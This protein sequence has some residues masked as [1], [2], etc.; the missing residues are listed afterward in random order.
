MKGDFSRVTASN[1]KKKHY[2][3]VLKQ[4]SRVL[5]DADNNEQV[6]IIAHQRRTRTI[7]TIGKCGAPIHNSG[8][9]IVSNSDGELLFSTGR[10]Y[11]EG[12][13]CETSPSETLS[14]AGFVQNSN[15]L[16]EVDD[17]NIDGIP[18][19]V[20]Q[21]VRIFSEEDALGE[22]VQIDQV[23][24][25]NNRLRLSANINAYRNHH[26]VQLQLYLPLEA[27]DFLLEGEGPEIPEPGTTMLAYLEVWQR[28]ITALEDPILREVALGGPDTDTRTQVITQLRTLAIEDPNSVLE[29]SSVIPEWEAL[30]APANGRLSTSLVP[31]NLPDDPCRLGESGGYLG[32]DNRLYRVEVH[33]GGTLG[34]DATFKWSRSNAAQ[35]YRVAEFTAIAATTAD[36]RLERQGR[37]HILALKVGDTIEISDE[38]TDLN[39]DQL[40]VMANITAVNDLIISVAVAA[41]DVTPFQDR[42]TLPKVRRWDTVDSLADAVNPITNADFE[43]GD[44]ITITF[45]GTTFEAGDYWVFAARTLTGDIEI[46]D[47]AKPH[48][49]DR[50]YCKLAV[51]K[52]LANGA[53]EIED[54]RPLFPPLTELPEG[55]GQ[56]CHLTI[57]P[58]PSWWNVLVGHPAGTHLQVCFEPGDYE[59]RETLTFNNLGTLTFF[60]AGKGSQITVINQESVFTFEDCG[61]VT[62]RDLAI[63]SNATA[64]NQ[65]EETHLNGAVTVYDCTSL[66]VDNVSLSCADSDSDRQEATCITVRNTVVD[67]ARIP[68]AGITGPDVLTANLPTATLLNKVVIRDCELTVGRFQ[69]GILVVN[70]QMAHLEA[71]RI[72]VRPGVTAVGLQ[73]IVVAGEI[74][75]QVVIQNNYVNRMLQGIHL[76]FSNDK[77]D[78]PEI[79]FFQGGS[80]NIYQNHIL[81]SIFSAFQEEEG[82]HGIFVGN[83][84]DLSILDNYIQLFRARGRNDQYPGVKVIGHWGRKMI[85]RNNHLE[86]DFGNVGIQVDAIPQKPQSPLWIVEQNI[87]SID[88]D[89][90]EI[91]QRDNV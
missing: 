3:Q 9:E 18:L 51:I 42:D 67:N 83:S 14:V 23:N 57:S 84:K 45:S 24:A 25:N 11:V 86:G 27:Q 65:P 17:L 60:G 69:T 68:G 8:F 82:R 64:P 37:D 40:E 89:D 22:L 91:I 87:A 46:L 34:N 1:A 38:Y 35:A 56:C 43:L 15:T 32:L 47:Q 5:L 53:I 76:G 63:H 20:G 62:L 4:Q 59:L 31:T 88:I 85:L 81:C 50:H 75:P 21:W 74:A 29:C 41:A 30:T 90:A 16:V 48:G 77:K 12:L 26:Q 80:I 49:I 44:G 36:L 54:C 2:N 13:L 66:I 52:T 73:G 72:A 70:A 6:S 61:D 39:V 79:G 71:N 33:Q 78:D 19:A 28:H 7:D 10:F 55:E 58:G